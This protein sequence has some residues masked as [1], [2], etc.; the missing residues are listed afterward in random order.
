MEERTT[1]EPTSLVCDVEEYLF[2]VDKAAD[3]IVDPYHI[4]HISK[5]FAD[6]RTRQ[7][8]FALKQAL[9]NTNIANI[10][11]TSCTLDEGVP[12][13]ETNCPVRAELIDNIMI[14]PSGLLFGR[15]RIKR[16]MDF[17]GKASTL[18]EKLR[19]EDQPNKS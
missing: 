6:R 19:L 9:N 1:S 18:A 15:L 14:S 8:Y 13:T 17:L 7:G 3:Q 4:G 10:E 5:T 16:T 11:C 2:Y 12:P